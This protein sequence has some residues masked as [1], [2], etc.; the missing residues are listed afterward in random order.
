[1]KQSSKQFSEKSN[2]IMSLKEFAQLGTDQVAYIRSIASAEIIK[3]FPKV[4]GLEPGFTLWA[5][6]SAN[7]DPLA[8]A[9]EPADVLSNAHDLDLHP[10]TLH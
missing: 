8:L 1:M 4:E 10:V 6:F 7:G 3:K 2:S 5:L 9:D